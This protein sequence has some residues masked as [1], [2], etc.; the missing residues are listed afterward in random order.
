MSNYMNKQKNKLT[1][2]INI[3]S[4]YLSLFFYFYF[5]PLL[6]SLSFSLSILLFSS[7]FLFGIKNK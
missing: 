6:P 4:I 7:F 2:H 1:K 3:F 5:F